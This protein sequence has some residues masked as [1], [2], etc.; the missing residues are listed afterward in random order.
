MT[1]TVKNY[2]WIICLI[3]VVAVLCLF[4]YKVATTDHEHAIQNTEVEAIVQEHKP[5]THEHAGLACC[6]CGVCHKH[7]EDEENENTIKDPAWWLRLIALGTFTTIM[8]SV[9]LGI[10]W[11]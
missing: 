7:D 8:M 4:T 1:R 11:C 6:P 3:L 10:F 2:L 9:I 5:H